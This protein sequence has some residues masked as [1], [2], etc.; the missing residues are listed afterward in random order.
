MWPYDRYLRWK[1]IGKCTMGLSTGYQKAI[2]PCDNVGKNKWSSYTFIM[3]KY[4]VGLWK[5]N[6]GYVSCLHIVKK[7]H[8]RVAYDGSILGFMY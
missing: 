7:F 2:N 5:F 8:G 3:G 6:H 1:W 4:H